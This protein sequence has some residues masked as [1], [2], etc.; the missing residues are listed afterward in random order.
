VK[1][2]HDFIE[3]R[4]TR[5]V[6]IVRKK[7]SMKLTKVLLLIYLGILTWILIFKLGVQFSYMAERRVNLIPFNTIDYTELILNVLIFVPLGIYIGLII[8]SKLIKN[9]FLVFLI[10]FIIE[11]FQFI[12]KIGAFDIT[13]LITNTS[14]GTL[15]LFI[16]KI[17]E[18]IFANK[19]KTQ[20]FINIIASISTLFMLLLLILLK[21]NKLPIRYQ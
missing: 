5:L 10:S 19:V 12:L 18:K 1:Y 2:E 7:R 15:G 20:K 16:L 8:K 13:D 21:L 4:R 6:R 11:S 14:G 3:N 9:I 17:I